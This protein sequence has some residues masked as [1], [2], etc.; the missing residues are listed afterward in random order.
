M[1]H[2]TL[3]KNWPFLDCR[4][5]EGGG[6]EWDWGARRAKLARKK[7]CHGGASAKKS[8]LVSGSNLSPG[9]ARIEMGE[10]NL[11]GRGVEKGESRVSL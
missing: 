3:R 10:G 2:L 5:R 4:Q 6:G 9:A 8:I 7:D 11:Y 1:L